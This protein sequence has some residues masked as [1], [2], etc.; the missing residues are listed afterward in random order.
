MKKIL[1]LGAGRIGQVHARNVV[2]RNDARLYAVVD[3]HRPAAAALAE[4]TGARV[5]DSA[6]AALA[7]PD[8]DA[9]MICTSTDTHV[10]MILKA[11]KANKP[12]FCEKPV[13][14]DLAK[15]NTCLAEVGRAGVPLLMGF[16]RRFDPTFKAL[17][18]RIKQGE[19]G[20]L[21]SIKITSR[22]PEPPPPAYV[23]VS[24]GLFRDMMIHDLDMARYLLP[25]EPTQ[26]FATGSVL[27]D[28]AIGEA[29]DIDT[30][31]VILKTPSGRLAHIDNSRRAAFG[32][33]Q[34]IEAFGQKGMLQANNPTPTAVVST[35]NT[36]R[37]SD[38]PLHFFLERYAAAYQAELAH[39]LA[40]LD[41]EERPLVTGEDGRRALVLAD[42]AN[43][44]LRSGRVVE[45]QP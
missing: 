36:G 7:D 6:D 35:T 2:A 11:A 12:I 30:A 40:V 28:K 3:V 9:V 42:A 16:N 20:E 17:R 4:A 31:M 23:K 14:L 1:L 33:D 8:V 43:Q 38:K 34:R 22:D 37:H 29:G 18:D 21:E 26:V 41:G 25:E 44:S 32:Y 39:F 24:G 45:V 27:I 15:V 13:D 5:F 19:L 10:E